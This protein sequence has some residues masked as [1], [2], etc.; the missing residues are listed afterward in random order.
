VTCDRARAAARKTAAIVR[1]CLIGGVC[2]NEVSWPG[3]EGNMRKAAWALGV[4]VL[5]AFAAA[6]C[7]T[8]Q[9]RSH[10]PAQ[11]A[12]AVMRGL[13]VAAQL[14]RGGTG[15]LLTSHALSLTTDDGRSWTPITPPGVRPR[16]VKGVF[17]LD[18]HH[19]WV[20]WAK[21][22]TGGRAGLE[23]SATADGGRSWS[24][25]PLG[26]PAWQF[27]AG[28]PAY[29][30]F[31]D[32]RHGWV[33]ADVTQT[34][35]SPAGVLFRTSD[36]G[37]SWQ[38][39]PMPVSGPVAFTSPRTGWLV[40]DCQPGIRPAE[41]FYVT[42]D[43]GRSWQAE[44][45]TPSA[46]YRRAQATYLLPAPAAPTAGVLAVAFGGDGTRA[47]MALYQAAV[48][49]GSWARKA[50]VPL[51]RP[52]GDINDLPVIVRPGTWLI[53][54]MDTRQVVKVTRG[55]AQQSAVRISG[56]P[57]GGLSAASF[58]SARTG[59]AVLATDRCAHF[60]SD[61]TQTSALYATTDGGAHWT[62]SA[63]GTTT[64]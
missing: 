23:V 14:V 33:A 6:G 10:R 25:S 12:P 59:W 48:H 64:A 54:S 32:P 60:K 53:V 16:S 24:T 28:E 31:T 61:C 50:V 18:P 46:G 4:A 52:A 44:T 57:D 55:G 41:R 43:G 37:A 34:P 58:T 47:V 7:G 17:F 20:A 51:G 42:A 29:I 27:A 38:Q 45:V 2:R 62:L 3:V 35:L 13:V 11:R 15:W 22:A 19:G 30:G 40:C 63:S 26:K 5:I 1:R 9:P 36:G 39:L 49:G 56:L 8:G 21:P